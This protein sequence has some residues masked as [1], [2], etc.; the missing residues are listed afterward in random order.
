MKKLDIKSKKGFTIIEVVL[1][2]AIAGLIFLMVF[3][4]LPNLQRT[5]RDT[6]RRNDVDRAS[7]SL[8]QYV[9]NNNALPTLGSTTEESEGGGEPSVIKK[10]KEVVYVDPA[11]LGGVNPNGS[12]QAFAW[13]YLLADGKD[14]FEDP[15]G[16]PYVIVAVECTGEGE[17]CKETTP[18]FGVTTETTGEGEATTE[19]N[20]NV[21][22]LYIVAGAG[23]GI[24]G[25]FE[26]QKGRR[27]FAM[28]MT[29]EGNGVYC[30]DN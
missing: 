19:V 28:A 26:V 16:D 15:N 20:A 6:Q 9:T 24:D 8:I 14:S 25:S 30:V 13:K 1:V 29:L 11:E 2:L 4:A 5:Q 18:G 23:C 7:A 17:E 21:G 27:K 22:V 3:I 12:W 10:A